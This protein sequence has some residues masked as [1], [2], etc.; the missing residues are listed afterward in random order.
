[1]EAFPAVLA[2]VGPRVRVDQEMGG[3]GGAPLEGL[4]TLLA[5]EGPLAVVN[6]PEKRNNKQ[7]LSFFL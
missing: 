6:G 7:L 4:A 5:R 2:G 1:M 3:E